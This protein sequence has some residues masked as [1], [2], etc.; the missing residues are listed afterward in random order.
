MK[1]MTINFLAGA[2]TVLLLAGCECIQTT[3]PGD[4]CFFPEEEKYVSERHGMQQA[5]SAARVDGTL[6][7]SH[8]HG[9]NLN[10]LGERKLALMLIDDDRTR[11][12]PVYMDLPAED[13][14]AE[15]RRAAV[16]TY[17]QARGVPTDQVT[18]E[19]GP[20][21]NGGTP[22]APL[23]ENMKKTDIAGGGGAAVGQ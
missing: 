20:N 7:P 3:G 6:Y 10:S 23:L 18:L 15:G 21:P 1:Q 19:V 8:F 9:K 16:L 13:E 14:F 11:P 5:A 12:L 4:E 17:L 2:A 22:V